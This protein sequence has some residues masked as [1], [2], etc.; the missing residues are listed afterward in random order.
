LNGKSVKVM[1]FAWQGWQL[2]VPDEWNPVKLRGTFEAGY[3][4]LSDI[5]RP[6]LGMRWTTPG[7][8]FDSKVWARQ[9]MVEEVGRLAADEAV[10]CK[11]ECCQDALLYSE[12][13]PPGRDVWLGTSRASG[14]TIEIVHHVYK[15][16]ESNMDYLLKGLRDSSREDELA[17]ATFDLSCRTAGGWRLESHRLNAG[18]LSLVF[19]RK[20]ERTA[21][22]QIA[23]AQLALK[24]MTI[25]RWL[26]EQVRPRLQRFRQVTAPTPVKIATGDGRL[27]D[28]L[29]CRL[30]RRKRFMW[31]RVLP[32][33]MC[34]AALHDE[35]RDRLVFIEAGDQS[36]AE[37]LA[38]SV[39]W[40][41]EQVKC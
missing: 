8:R 26:Q 19:A 40:G 4:L 10:E 30:D 32:A 33:M 5:H 22:R 16:E 29:S 2:R 39:G 14:R 35:K 18:D 36:A 1:I 12:A 17:W 9:A 20:S 6:R 13:D 34:A 21:V 31:N 37:E 41:S 38:R 11:G 15:G 24:R 25:E 3:A 23:V 28:G 7:R 27:L